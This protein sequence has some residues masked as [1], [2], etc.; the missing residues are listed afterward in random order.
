[1]SHSDNDIELIQ[2]RLAAIEHRL[3]EL[4]RPLLVPLGNNVERLKKH[5]VARNL[6]VPLFPCLHQSSSTRNLYCV[7]GVVIQDYKKVHSTGCGYN[8]KLAKDRAAAHAL[9]ELG[10][11]MTDAPEP[12]KESEIYES[13]SSDSQDDYE[14]W[15][16]YT[17][18][19][20]NS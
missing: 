5:C 2:T 13:G 16:S 6:G 8:H 3:G 14:Y 4:D 20:M 17:T 10:W 7:Y 15:K 1:M 19:R 18:K 9:R 11:H 12:S